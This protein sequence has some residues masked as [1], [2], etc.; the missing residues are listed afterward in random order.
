M[1]NKKRLAMMAVATT[2][3]FPTNLATSVLA[4]NT[5]P[6]TSESDVKPD[7]TQDTSTNT[8]PTLIDSSSVKDGKLILEAGAY[9]LDSDIVLTQTIEIAGSITL[10]LNNRKISSNVKSVFDVN[11]KDAFLEIVGPGTI[12]STFNQDTDGAIFRVSGEKGQLTIGAGVVLK[13]DLTN[14]DKAAAPYIYGISVPYDAAKS[15]TPKDIIINATGVT[16]NNLQGGISVN[17]NIPEDNPALINLTK[18]IMD[19]RT[20]G[21]D[22]P[23]DDSMGIYQAGASTI[24]IVDSEITADKC[25]I[26]TR[27]GTLNISGGKVTGSTQ[28][29][30]DVTQNGSGSTTAYAGIAVDQHAVKTGYTR[31][32]SV[33]VT[34]GTTITG[35]IPFVI[36][37]SVEKN[38]E[39]VTDVDPNIS[40]VLSDVVWTLS[41]SKE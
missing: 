15:V 21:T 3:V 7:N 18:V 26:Q 37:D 13:T 1:L 2:M 25:A 34:N 17:G 10:D 6:T 32:I 36:A 31:K 41:I 30:T 28:A 8:G 33:N 40:I 11:T 19:L 22:C 35:H 5:E 12:V 39:N 14:V 24:N 16:M 38:Q 29:P 23:N 9:K 20:I 4:T 27:S